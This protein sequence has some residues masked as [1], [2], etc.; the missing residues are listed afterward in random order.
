MNTVLVPVSTCKPSS[1]TVYTVENCFDYTLRG[2]QQPLATTHFATLR[3]HVLTSVPLQNCCGLILSV[4]VN[5]D[6]TWL[7][8]S[9]VVL[10]IAARR[11]LLRVYSIVCVFTTHYNQLYQLCQGS[12]VDWF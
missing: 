3:K 1:V 9:I 12:A 4:F 5:I 7:S 8:S 2:G 10:T 6:L 11:N